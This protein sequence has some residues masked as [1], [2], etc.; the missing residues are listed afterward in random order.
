MHDPYFCAT[1]GP[2]DLAVTVVVVTALAMA[3][4][5]VG[6][7][8]LRLP[9]NKDRGDAAFDAYKA[10]MS[11]VGVVL[12][13]SLVQANGVLHEVGS[14]VGKEAAALE[15]TDRVLLRIG[16]PEWVALRPGLAIYAQTLI[17]KEWPL[18][19]TGQ[20]SDA[21]DNAYT[22]VSKAARGIPPD[23]ARQQAM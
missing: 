23:D 12:A 16:K 1:A 13:F 5:H 4:P 10:I 15:A 19:S 9:E 6:R 11:M 8:A 22:A 14:L 3:A 7:H 18:L 21:A 20:R 17:E 2:R